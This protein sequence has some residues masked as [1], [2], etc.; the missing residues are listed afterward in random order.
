MISHVRP[1]FGQFGTRVTIEGQRIRN[2]GSSIV[3]VSLSGIP[4]EILTQSAT[5]VVVRAGASEAK[6][7]DSVWMIADSGAIIRSSDRFTYL[8]K[9]IVN[10]VSPA[11]GQYN[12]RVTIVGSGLLGGGTSAYQV[13]FG[14]LLAEIESHS[15]TVIIV[16]APS[17]SAMSR[18]STP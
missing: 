6:N 13:V 9:G 10:S 18:Q 11:F 4:A 1:S 17:S 2:G 7:A 8:S 16:R 3:S 14:L 12:T 5:V 15:S